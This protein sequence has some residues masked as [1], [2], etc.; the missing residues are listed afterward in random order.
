M[1]GLVFRA[2]G[3][4][5]CLTAKLPLPAA[6]NR[7]ALR[8]IGGALGKSGSEWHRIPEEAHKR[9]LVEAARA[10]AQVAVKTPVNN[11]DDVVVVGAVD[12]TA[13][14]AASEAGLW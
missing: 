2:G 5:L 6:V 9:F 14:D 13:V 12:M 4:L 11:P 8:D 10:E 1:L 7:N 3:A